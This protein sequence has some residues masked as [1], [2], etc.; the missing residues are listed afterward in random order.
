MAVSVQRYQISDVDTAVAK[1]KRHGAKKIPLPTFEF[2]NFR[3]GSLHPP[4]PQKK[5][6]VL[7]KW[8]YESRRWDRKLQIA[9]FNNSIEKSS[10]YSLTIHRYCHRSG[11]VIIIIIIIIPSLYILQCGE[12]AA[13]NGNH[14][15]FVYVF[16]SILNCRTYVRYATRGFTEE[17]IFY[18]SVPSYVVAI[19]GAIP[20]HS[21]IFCK[22]LHLHRGLEL[23]LM[24]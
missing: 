15:H 9:V 10:Y 1:T 16:Y 3:H 11:I 17:N 14:L 5:E 7:V 13:H 22:T 23:L 24:K 6:L 21:R 2:Y 18:I 8:R 4:P 20:L 12:L 19:R